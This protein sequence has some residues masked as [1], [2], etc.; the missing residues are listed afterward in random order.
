MTLRP[1]RQLYSALQLREYDG[2]SEA[3][4]STT[5]KSPPVATCANRRWLRSHPRGSAYT[6]ATTAPNAAPSAPTWPRVARL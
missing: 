1:T 2:T 6:A 5:V 3:C 4:A